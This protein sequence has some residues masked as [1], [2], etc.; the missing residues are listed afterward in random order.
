[1]K[2]ICDRGLN[3][4]QI[5][6]YRGSVRQC[7]WTRDGYIGN[8]IDDTVEDI[9]HGEKAE[10]IRE[11]LVNGDY[12]L[13]DVDACP[14]LAMNDL[15]KHIIE[16]EEVPTY[17]TELYLG[18]ER[19]CNYSCTSCNIHKCMEETKDKDLEVYYKNIEEKIMPILPHIKKI[20]ANGCGEL[21]C[22]KHIL[23]ILANWKPLFAPEE[24]E[25][26]LESNG[27]MFD[28]KHWKQIENL[29]QY[30][31]SVAI[32]VMSFDEPVY[33]YLSGT[34][35]P[36]TNVENN[37]KYI[38]HLREK[39]IINYFEI[40]TVVQEQNFR[41]MPEFVKKC[42]DEYN[43]DYIR[44]RPY[45]S[46]G[47]QKPEEVWI[48]D[49]RNPEHPY[50]HEYKKV[51]SHPI[52]KHPLVHDWSG[53]LDTVQKTYFPY[54]IDSCKFRIISDL[55]N[56][57]NIIEDS[58]SKYTENKD[59]IIYGLGAIGK[60]LIDKLVDN[61]YDVKYIIDQNPNIGT[62]KNINVYSWNDIEAYS[63]AELVIVTPIID[64]DAIKN[65]LL[66]Y[67]YKNIVSVKD[68]VNNISLNK[69]LKGI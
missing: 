32:S 17:P 7:S 28:E 31:L 3:W 69:E 36:I 51:M 9:Y 19:I 59:I 45:E 6:D 12:S 14:Y 16:Y 34:K 39:G 49:I 18:F 64:D 8:L 68:I 4:F 23:N 52:L 41:E 27:S 67:G 26:M 57:R 2:K 58:I 24:V 55:Y 1:M 50:Y 22:S 43:P 44:L 42:I 53:G 60:V 40:A 21:F 48:T 65:N 63:R 13:C 54:K 35:L 61:N 66:E 62:Y 20:S 10:R 38:R 11:R 56:E 47:A 29:G 46:W 15:D 33:Q 25:V 30:N 5:Y 37:L